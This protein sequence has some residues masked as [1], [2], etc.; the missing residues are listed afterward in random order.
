M[1]CTHAARTARIHSKTS[2]HRASV[3]V[4]SSRAR[5]GAGGELKATEVHCRGR[6]ASRFA[7]A[8]CRR[9]KLETLGDCRGDV[10]C[11]SLTSVRRKSRRQRSARDRRKRAHDV[12][13]ARS[14]MRSA[15]AFRLHRSRLPR[16]ACAGCNYGLRGPWN[17]EGIFV[18]RTARETSA[19]YRASLTSSSWS[20]PLMSRPAW[21][22]RTADT[23]RG[24]QAPKSPITGNE[25]I[26][27]GAR[28]T[29]SAV[30]L[31][32]SS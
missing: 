2:G 17:H 12:G 25:R 14:C 16:T 29:G 19:T 24:N 9:L 26:A 15:S 8:G 3:C 21:A 4:A 32:I 23:G 20:S 18:A 1:R 13:F 6:K 22:A 30:P 27:R 11:S 7:C 5:T 28:A 10:A 31:G